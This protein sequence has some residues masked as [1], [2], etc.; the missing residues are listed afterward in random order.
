VPRRRDLDRELLALGALVLASAGVRFAVSRGVAAPWIAPDEHLY[1]LLGRSLVHGEGLAVLGEGVPY[2]SSLYPLLVGLPFLGTEPSTGV[3]GVQATQA[4]LMSATAVPIF[5]W[6]RPLTGA[7]FALVPALLTVLVPGLVYGGLLMSEALYYPAAV[8]AAWAL[9]RCLGDP[10]PGAQALFLG[11]FALALATRLQAV[12]F[13]AALV[14]ALGL[15]SMFERSF[16]PF[17]RLFPTLAIVGAAGIAWIG[18]RL[19]LGGVGEL[20][21]AYAPLAE[22]GGYSLGGVLRSLSWHAGALALVTVAVP[23]VALGV[24]AW[25]ALRGREGDARVRA[26]VATAVAYLTVTVVEV[27]AFASRFVDHVTERQLLSVAPPVFVAFAV[28]LRRG[29]PRPWPATPIVAIAVAAPTL[30]LPLDRVATPSAAVDAPSTI[31]LEKLGRHLPETV[32]ETVYAG[33]AALFVALAVLLPRRAGAALAAVVALVLVAGSSVA[34]VEFRDRSRD[35]RLATFAGE[36]TDW[37]DRSGARDA[38][39]LLTSDRLWP[40]AWA[41]LFWNDSIARIVRLPEVEPIG[42]VPQDVVHPGPDGVLRTRAGEAVEAPYVVAPA[43]VLVV[44]ESMASAPASEEQHGL[45]VWRTEGPIRLSQRVVGLRPNGDLHGGE[46]AEIRVYACG[47]GTLELT[48]LGKQGAP[49]RVVLDGT[50]LAERSVPSGHVWHAGIPAPRSADG[51]GTCV[52]DLQ[53]DGLVGSTRIV[54]VRNGR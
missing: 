16:A 2:Y 15:L 41:E 25:E 47:G 49:T 34:S 7:R 18:A 9:A 44:G 11:L 28:W 36:P 51:S 54:F 21:G 30:L 37:I 48:V 50:V 23:L 38:T 10:T 4:L 29:L 39:L 12:G 6:A 43:P 17:R 46:R 1:G 31:L 22:A 35:A 5:L 13:V 3:T 42:V 45:T 20:L 8:L 33:A 32:L 40:S 26:L 52:F 24:L 27:G 14:V 19:A 53:T